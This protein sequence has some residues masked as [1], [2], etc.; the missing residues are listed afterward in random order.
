MK[1]DWTHLERHRNSRPPFDSRPGERFGA[2]AFRRNGIGIVVIATDGGGP[3]LGWEH[4]SVSIPGIPRCPTWDEICFIK[5]LFWDATE[6]VVQFH[7]KASEYVNRH[8]YVLHLWK[9]GEIELPPSI[10]VG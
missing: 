9:R 3:G 6:T 2:F 8:P 5:D 10:F 4:V 7:P 1:T